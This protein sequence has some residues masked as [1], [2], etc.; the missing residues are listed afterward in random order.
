MVFNIVGRAQ[1][2][3]LSYLQ[4]PRMVSELALVSASE[5]VIES[6]TFPVRDFCLKVSES[7]V[8]EFTR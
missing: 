5:T 6:S 1:D 4:K 7:P 3:E 8:L 2:S